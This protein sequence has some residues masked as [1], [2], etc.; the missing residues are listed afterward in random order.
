MKNVSSYYYHK[1]N[2]K[3]DLLKS[4]YLI[5]FQKV[6][7]DSVSN[8]FTEVHHANIEEEDADK[9]VS[10]LAK[11]LEK[12]NYSCIVLN[13]AVDWTFSTRLVLRNDECSHLEFEQFNEQDNCITWTEDYSKTRSMF[14]LATG[15]K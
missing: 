4:P 10:Y 5:T 8:L 6:F 2:F 14:S 9:T 3:L 15:N 13:W 7:V 1:T 12:P 11:E